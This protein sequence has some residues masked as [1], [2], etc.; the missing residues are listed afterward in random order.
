MDSSIQRF[1]LFGRR[2]AGH[3]TKGLVE[4]NAFLDEAG[5]GDEA[6]MGVL[7]RAYIDEL[8][9]LYKNGQLKWDR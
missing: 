1:I 4:I 9:Q 3:G 6:L 2:F 7:M 5:A 8:L